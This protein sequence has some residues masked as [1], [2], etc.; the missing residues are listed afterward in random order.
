MLA[1]IDTEAL[2]ELVWIAPLAAVAVTA[3]FSACV[4]GATRSTDARRAG[5]GGQAFVW[6]LLALFTGVLVLAE[7]VAG[8]AV[9]AGGG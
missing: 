3:T 5:H 2:F 8:I 7:V 4:L 9:I 6:M 1:S